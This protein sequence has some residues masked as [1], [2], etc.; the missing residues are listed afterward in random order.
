MIEITVPVRDLVAFCHRCGDIDHRF[1]P[2]PTGEQ[3]V[4]GH[5][6]VYGRRPDSYRSEYAVQYRHS[7]GDLQ[8]LLRGRADGYDPAAAVVEEIKTCRVDPAL[9][10]EAVVRMHLA[11]ARIYA[12]IIAQE[13]GLAQVEV[14]LTW[15]NI[16][17]A[18]EQ[19]LSQTYTREE[20]ADFLHSSLQRFGDWLH[21]LARLRQQRDATLATLEFPYGSFR[22]G[23]REIAELVYKCIDQAGQLLVEAPTGIGKTAAVLYP[24]LKALATGKHERIVYVTAKTVGRRAAEDTLHSF[25]DAG[26]QLSALSLTA[27]ESICLSPGKACHGDDCPYARGYYDRLPQALDAALASPSLQR[28]DIE[29]LACRFDVCPYQ[30]ALDLLPWVD[31]VIADLHY[32]YS[33]T[34][35]LGS[36]MQQDERRWTVLLDEAHNLPD[37]ARGM[38]RASLAK[39]DLMALKRSSPPALG[40]AL[41]KI[42]RAMLGLLKEQWQEQYYDSREQLPP[43]LL[44]AL[45]Q[46]VATTGEQLGQLPALLHRQ[47]LLLDFYFEVLQF[48]RVADNWGEDFRFECT[49][50]AGRQSLRVALTCLDPAR[51]LGERQQPL[52]AMAAFSAT[53]SP[54]HWTRAALGLASDSVYRRLLSPF[55]QSQ[56]EVFLAT[57]VDT[58]YSQRRHTLRALAETVLAWLRRETG[59]CI[60]YFPSYRYL[61]DCLQQ[62]QRAGLGDLPRRLWVQRR[63]RGASGREELL[64]LLEECRNV[65]ALCILG[66][67]F[68]EG[69]DLPGQ[70]LTSVV[71]VGVGLPQFNRETEQLRDWYQ[72]RYSAGFE[73]AYL[74]PGMQKVDQALGRV[75]RGCGDRGRALLIDSRYRER[76]YRELLPPW[77]TYSA[78]PSG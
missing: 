53:L 29:S 1:S 52:H 30:L 58:R 13:Q 67:V 41:E 9:I 78:W 2:S 28:V 37:R 57:G 48:Q 3:G 70:R 45:Q 19:P 49:R 27:K 34:A 39:A 43:D 59:N 40:A 63:D 75:V 74:Y 60:V 76:Q 12:A 64:P 32:V 73:F 61:E 36:M 11:Q 10:P 31:V 46:F 25:A 15:F 5:Q 6:R 23:Q 24:A 35:T 55:D 51:L 8:L 42:N 26:L 71:V 50:D 56:L 20:L 21:T 69:I 66:G 22:A 72:R 65:A 7:Q 17:S 18:R 54:P 68:G 77:W 4:A 33:L 62:M 47:P 44:Q 38:Y 16:D 14:R